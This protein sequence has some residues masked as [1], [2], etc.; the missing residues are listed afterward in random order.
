M[1]TI[2][3]QEKFL[4]AAL[5]LFHEKGFKGTTMKDIA[6]AMNFEVANVYNYIESKQALLEESLF[7]I[8]K[9]FHTGIDFILASTYAPIDQLRELIRLHI[10][11]SVQY[12]YEIALHTNE[13]RNLGAETRQQFVQERSEYEQK[14][15][16]I[17]ER[18]ITDGSLRQMD[19]GIATQAVLSAVR[20]LYRWCTDNQGQFNPIELE[21]QLMEFVIGGI[22]NSAH[23]SMDDKRAE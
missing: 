22:A 12:P 13:W 10:R 8:S 11:L 3:K 9:Q 17:L 18:G 23:P 16:T 19:L 14:V 7:S 20:W 5:Q 4:A 1:P 21:K 6:E 15:A 2:S